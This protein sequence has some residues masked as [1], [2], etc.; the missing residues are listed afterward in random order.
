MEAKYDVFISYASEDQKVTEDICRYLES[1][2][3]K[4]FVNYRDLPYG[5]I[6]DKAIADA[7][8]K[9]RMMVVVFSEY[10]N[11]SRQTDIEFCQAA[12]KEKPI[13]TFRLSDNQFTGAKRYYLMNVHYEY[14]KTNFINIDAF[15]DTAKRFDALYM[16]IC[17]MLGIPNKLTSI[18]SASPIAARKEKEIFI[19]YSRNDLSKVKLVKEEIDLALN[20]VSWMDLEGI[21]SGD[22]FDNI[23]VEAIENCRIMLFMLTQNSM[24]SDYALKEIGY[25]QSL[26][27]RIVIVKIKECEMFGVFRF[28][29]QYNDQIDWDAKE[30][31]EKLFHNLRTWIA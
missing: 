22:I 19:S 15:P 28:R 1:H 29:Y 7:I 12:D 27:K 20:T 4:C 11:N 14:Y 30:Q 16:K 18:I 3:I 13:I 25:A 10:F 21:E 8:S 9:S 26:G 23:I 6:L 5:V 31:R 24:K 2:G 17:D